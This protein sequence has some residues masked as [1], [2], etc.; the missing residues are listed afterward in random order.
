MESKKLAKFIHKAIKSLG[1]GS[2]KKAEAELGP[3]LGFKNS[4][5]WITNIGNRGDAKLSQIEACA[6]YLGLSLFEMAERAL[7]P[8]IAQPKPK[9]RQP[10]IL[11]E[12]IES[13]GSGIPDSFL[14]ALWRGRHKD[15][16]RTLAGLGSVASR[17]NAQQKEGCITLAALCFEAVDDFDKALW[18][19][20]FC[21]SAVAL[22]YKVALLAKLGSIEHALDCVREA[23][24]LF[25][26]AKNTGGLGE[27]LVAQAGCLQHLKQAGKALGYYESSLAYSDEMRP[28]YLGAAHL[29]LGLMN[30]SGSPSVARQHLSVA[31]SCFERANNPVNIAKTVWASAALDE[32]N[33]LS[34]LY[35]AL[36]LM[37]RHCH[38]DTALL[39]IDI[40]SAHLAVGQVEKASLAVAGL[41][42]LLDGFSGIPAANIAL[43]NLSNLALDYQLTIKEC[44]VTRDAIFSRRA[45]TKSR[46]E[47][48]WIAS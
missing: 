5:R 11:Q 19:Y 41:F 23:K 31:I 25:L 45:G 35:D 47:W 27:C 34:V 46:S 33:V 13:S 3:A 39:S 32:E 4:T 9:E 28:D 24:E 16:L 42:E 37:P 8:K 17:T 48:P 44:N 43:R 26:T 1:H 38:V 22:L 21:E 18:C 36:K 15:P 40:A 30:I 20:S 29:G 12:L 10:A 14:D 2:V 6:N 7:S